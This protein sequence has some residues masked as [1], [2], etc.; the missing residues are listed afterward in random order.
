MRLVSLGLLGTIGVLLLAILPAAGAAAPLSG[1]VT[2]CSSTWSCQFTFNTSAGTGWAHGVGNA[3]YG[4][5]GVISLQLPGESKAS[6]NLSYNTWIGSLIGT[7][8]YW[9]EG[10]F[11]GTDVNTGYVVFGN[12][13][14]NYTITCHG[15]SGHGGGCTYTYTTDNGTIVVRFTHAEQT[16][17]SLS[18][19]PTSINVAGKTT[20]TATV[21]NLWNST[22]YPAGKIH[23]AS[24]GGGKFSNMGTCTLSSNGTCT[25]TWHPSDNTCSFSTLSATYGGTAKFYH[26]S[27]STLEGVTGGC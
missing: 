1:V 3:G 21:T 4:R 7:Y 25:F 17:T 5:A 8:T 20:C 18:C 26:S 24:S 11:F 12:T 23:F 16:M 15:H 2:T 9:T 14:T 22:N 19:S 13:N 6:Y 27:G 10:Q